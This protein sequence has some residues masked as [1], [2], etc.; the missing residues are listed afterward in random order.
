MVLCLKPQ[1]EGGS[2]SYSNSQR[3]V[4]HI[5]SHP[6]RGSLHSER[7]EQTCVSF[8]HPEHPTVFGA[9][10]TSG[11]W[12][13]YPNCKEAASASNPLAMLAAVGAQRHRR[14]GQ[15]R[16]LVSEKGDRN[17]LVWTF[18]KASRA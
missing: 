11:H 13:D 2:S 14:T 4:G 12:K 1:L 9:W 18:C 3:A 16:F 10:S 15:G 5:L 7:D 17:R 8:S 6:I